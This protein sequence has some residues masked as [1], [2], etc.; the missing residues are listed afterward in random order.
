MK[1]N[2]LKAHS[3]LLACLLVLFASFAFAQSAYDEPDE[4]VNQPSGNTPPATSNPRPANSQ[5]VA[6]IVDDNVDISRETVAPAEETD[7][8]IEG[9]ELNSGTV[10]E[11]LKTET[12]PQSDENLF[13]PLAILSGFRFEDFSWDKIRVNPQII[14][15]MLGVFLTAIF[16]VIV[17]VLVFFAKIGVLPK[18]KAGLS[19][20]SFPTKDSS[21]FSSPILGKDA[22]IEA[23]EVKPALKAKQAEEKALQPS[24]PEQQPKKIDSMPEEKTGAKPSE[25]QE[26]K[27]WLDGLIG[28]RE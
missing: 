7:E 6:E 9:N 13:F 11:E 5:P 15:L 1:G 24:L 12:E 14:V 26:R 20:F 2:D 22:V 23:K 25:K 21:S 8:N 19:N 16:V 18:M 10:L 4:P 27:N 3:I 28:L 17:A